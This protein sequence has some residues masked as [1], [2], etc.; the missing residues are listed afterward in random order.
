MTQP[1]ARSNRD[2]TDAELNNAIAQASF[3]VSISLNGYLAE[4]TRRDGERLAER[5]TRTAEQTARTASRALWTGP[6]RALSPLSC[7]PLW[8]C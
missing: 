2:L 4:A 3:N 5:S 6:S 1:R 8:P 7:R